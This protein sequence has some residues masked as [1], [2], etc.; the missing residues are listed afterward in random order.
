M[1]APQQRRKAQ[2]KRTT[3]K[4]RK[5][6]THPRSSVGISTFF[7]FFARILSW[8]VLYNVFVSC[9]THPT[10]D[11]PAVCHVYASVRDTVVPHV[12]PYYEQ[13][14]KEYYEQYALPYVEKATPLVT[15]ARDT[16]IVPAVQ[17]A[18][19]L[20]QQ[21]AHPHVQT[22]KAKAQP[23]VDDYAQRWQTIYKTYGEEHV[24]KAHLIALE[25]RDKANVFYHHDVLPIY[26]YIAPHA[27]LAAIN[28]ERIA[29]TTIIPQ[30]KITLER[31]WVLLFDHVW[32]PL[33]QIYDAR[34]APEIEKY[35]G[36]DSKL[37]TTRKSPSAEGAFNAAAFAQA[38][39][40]S[41][42]SFAHKITEK[43][44][45]SGEAAKQQP[46]F[47]REEERQIIEDD[48][49]LWRKKFQSAADKAI[50]DLNDEVTKL[51]RKVEAEKKPDVEGQF[52]T[53]DKAIKAENAQLKATI[54]NIAREFKPAED[55]QETEELR[56]AAYEKLFA[57]TRDAGTHIRDR[58]YAI[59]KDRQD[60]M[61][62]FADKVTSIIDGHIDVVDGI[63]DMGVQEIG[64]KWSWKL[65]GVEYKDWKRYHQLK[66]DFEDIRT[67]IIR[68]AEENAK[69]VE[70]TEWSEAQ[71]DDKAIAIAKS[72]AEE[73]ARLKR[74]GK[75]KIALQDSSDDF[76]T[77]S[78]LGKADSSE[79]SKSET[80]SSESAA[81]QKIL[82]SVPTD[83]ESVKGKISSKIVVGG[84]SAGYVYGETITY[85]DEESLSE[86]AAHLVED[87]GQ[88]VNNALSDASRAVSEALYGTATTANAAEKATALAAEKYQQALSAASSAL[89]GTQQPATASIASV[90]SEQYASAVS[91]ASIAIYGTPA[92]FSEK[93]QQAFE[94]ALQSATETYHEAVK[95]ASYAAYG[96]PPSTREKL[97][98][99]AADNYQSALHAA[100]SA[101]S[102][103]IDSASTA[104][105][106]EEQSTYESIMSRANERYSSATASAQGAYAT[107]VSAASANVATVTDTAAIQAEKVR[108]LIEEL[109][110]GKEPDF[111]ES[112]YSRFNEAIS[113]TAAPAVASATSYASEVIST[114]TEAAQDAVS[115]ATEAASAAYTDASSVASSVY[116][117]ASSA[118]D[119]AVSSA[120]S[121]ADE[122][123]S[124]ASSVADEAY[125][126]ASSAIAALTPPPALQSAIDAVN[127]QV[128]DILSQASVQVY[129]TT[130]GTVE[131]ATS[132]VVDAAESVATQISE[133]IYGT[134][135]G[136]YE[137]ATLRL[138]AAA[139][140]ASAAVSEAIYGTATPQ[141]TIDIA[142]SIVADQAAS[143]SS[144]VAENAAA[145]A[146][147]VGDA[148][149]AVY[150][151]GD[152]AV[153]YAKALEESGYARV[154]ELVEDARRQLE[155]L[156]VEKVREGAKEKLVSVKKESAS[157]EGTKTAGHIKSKIEEVKSKVSE[158]AERIRDEL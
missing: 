113:F 107:L 40:D 70:V 126:T 85:E 112:V 145:A 32:V 157:T 2:R 8:Y 79:K 141:G 17:N 108:A 139:A 137:S 20:Y 51:A 119:E 10:E 136:A 81:K 142:T 54:I 134:Q 128:H 56:T 115:Y 62:E 52:A 83:V 75:K 131:Q 146:S 55:E 152:D 116:T 73:I 14:G 18:G 84:A 38:A 147:A 39:V 156:I 49:K 82:V 74:V 42:S 67:P 93:A 148:A 90:A 151:Y 125:S 104:I 150:Q 99:A 149:N 101:Y 50:K 77:E 9:P 103:A 97:V 117:E 48:L 19:K 43:V 26:R 45:G 69:L 123:Y 72:E 71:W 105:Y 109:V 88:A 34:I 65:D 59:R 154:S 102:Q 36:V 47:S 127:D 110:K 21:Y 133:A 98:A 58:I 122:A 153:R 106:G 15:Q 28:A 31:V 64:M 144:V 68:S 111:T 11:S 57:A 25:V 53:L 46:K 7:N 41:A 44:K 86:K 140:S 92:P 158:A 94:N 6:T 132:A 1:G 27:R 96:E 114:A 5:T 13:Y 24:L 143:A 33:S 129:G 66:K 118:V 80:V 63:I 100:Q 138:S 155:G 76:S 120:S 16:V 135:T 22:V 78:F 89:Y 87:A 29:R 130:K 12:Q 3:Q 61:A 4:P 23:F 35:T 37:Q 60:Y 124:T 91:A 121:V 30:A 95:K